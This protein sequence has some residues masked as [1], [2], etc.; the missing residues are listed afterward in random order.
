MS[1][2]QILETKY[3]S[4][5]KKVAD[6]LAASSL[7]PNCDKSKIML[8]YKPPRKINIPNIQLIYND[9]Y[10]VNE[11]N[12][13]SLIINYNLTW[14]SH[15]NKICS[16]IFQSA[17]VINCSKTTLPNYILLALY[18]TLILAHI[19]YCILAWGYNFKR[20]YKIKK[21]KVFIIIDKSPIVDHTDPKFIKFNL[22]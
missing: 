3:N 7:S 13:L 15:G 20:V 2:R 14:I 5:M 6:W 4:E 8:F 21:K 16:K 1:N 19:H 18:N 22:T 9:I 10:Y 12:F 17:G 11:F